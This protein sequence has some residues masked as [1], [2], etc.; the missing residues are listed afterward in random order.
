MASRNRAALI[1]S[2]LALPFLVTYFL[3]D[4]RLEPIYSFLGSI[5]VVSLNPLPIGTLILLGLTGAYVAARPML[6]KD[7]DGKRTFYL[8]NTVLAAILL[9]FF[10]WVVIGIAQIW[11]TFD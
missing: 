8:L 2:L 9:V 1:G 11:L 3:V 5:G 4:H 6:G 7:A 10:V